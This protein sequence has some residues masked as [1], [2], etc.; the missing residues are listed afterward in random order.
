VLEVFEQTFVDLTKG[1]L[2]KLKQKE[3]WLQRK[4]ETNWASK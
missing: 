4:F 2:L 3:F 1:C